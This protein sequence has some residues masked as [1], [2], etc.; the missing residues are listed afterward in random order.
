MTDRWTDKRR[1]II[2]NVL[3]NSTRGTTFLK[4]MDIF[5][6]PKIAEKFFKLMDDIVEEVGEENVV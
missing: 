1:R 5:V 4:S 3:V 6:I 2:L